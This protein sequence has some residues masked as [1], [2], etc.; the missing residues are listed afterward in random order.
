MNSSFNE[1]NDDS[2]TLYQIPKLHKN[3]YRN[4]HIAGSSACSIKG[5]SVTMTTILS[6]VKKRVGELMTTGGSDIYF[7]AYS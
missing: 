5:L 2:P 1:A 3:P 7:L 6:A 4:R